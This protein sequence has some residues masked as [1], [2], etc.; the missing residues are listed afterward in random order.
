MS[1][2]GVKRT[3]IVCF[4]CPL[5]TQSGHEHPNLLYRTRHDRTGLINGHRGETV[6]LPLPTTFL[7]EV[8]RRFSAGHYDIFQR[9]YQTGN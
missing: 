8:Q 6:A 7:K 4:R 1:A 5:L 2:F 3:L 9:R